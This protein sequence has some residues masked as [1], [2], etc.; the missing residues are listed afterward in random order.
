VI[1][2][3]GAGKT[4]LMR[5]IT[6]RSSPTRHAAD[7]RHGQARLRRPVTR[8]ARPRQDRLGG[9]LRRRRPDHA[10]RAD[11]QQP[12]LRRR[13]Q[14]QGHRPAEEGRQALRRRAQPPAPGEAAA[15]RRQ[16]AAARRAHQRPRPTRCARSRRRCSRSPAAPSSSRT[17]AGSSTGS[18][19]T[20]SRSRATRRCAGSRATSRPTRASATSS[21]APR[22]TGPNRITYKKLVRNV[23]WEHAQLLWELRHAGPVRDAYLDTLAVSTELAA[24]AMLV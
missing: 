16:P 21:S 1:G 20:C 4:T 24:R 18:R 12:R 15:Q 7:R 8:R 3:N 19:R 5:M 14:L 10:R 6:G 11:G 22:P 9:D 13:L 23:A 2:P 17:I